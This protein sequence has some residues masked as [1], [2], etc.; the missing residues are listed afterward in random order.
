VQRPRRSA[1]GGRQLPVRVV[2]N[3]RMSQ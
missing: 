1:A 2:D 3:F